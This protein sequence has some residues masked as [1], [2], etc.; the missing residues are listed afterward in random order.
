LL[1]QTIIIPKQLGGRGISATAL[2]S[3]IQAPAA[4]A[5]DDEKCVGKNINENETVN[6]KT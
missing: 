4:T 3:N 6:V 5:L 2:L 1:Q